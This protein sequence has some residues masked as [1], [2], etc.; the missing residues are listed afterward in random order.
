MAEFNINQFITLK[1]ENKKTNIYIQGT[2]F[3]QCKNVIFINPHENRQQGII[4]SIDEAKVF[5]TSEY[6]EEISP[7]FLGITPEE[8]FWAHCSNL[9]VWA[10]YNYNTSLLHSNLAFPILKTLAEVGDPTAKK[11]FKNEIIKKFEECEESLFVNTISYLLDEEYYKF[12]NEIELEVL[13]HIL[14]TIFLKLAKK[15]LYENFDRILSTRSMGC[16]KE[17][18]LKYLMH[19]LIRMRGKPSTNYI[20][21]NRFILTLNTYYNL[22]YLSS[23]K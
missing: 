22:R 11:V 23:E 15:G 21:N 5:L 10:E 20:F 9:Q 12:L 3:L 17:E 1:L 2:K 6:G 4:G 13:S 18:G 19:K 8:E 14:K 16:L 7:Q